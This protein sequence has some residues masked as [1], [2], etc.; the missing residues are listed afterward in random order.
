M[1][2]ELRAKGVEALLQYSVVCI[3]EVHERSIE[4]ELMLTTVKDMLS[5]AMAKGGGG[6][7]PRVVLMSATADFERYRAY[8]AEA[9]PRGERVERYDIPDLGG[10]LRRIL[11]ETEV[12][13]RYLQ[14]VATM[15]GLGGMAIAV[16][17]AQA[18]LGESMYELV[19]NLTAHIV[20]GGGRG[21][22]MVFLPTY[23]DMEAVS[24]LIGAARLRVEVVA[25]HSSVVRRCRL[26][27]SNP[28]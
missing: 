17:T 14:D 27:L 19:V 11:P 5:S 8:F 10:A 12:K 6:G 20:T 26:T 1:V 4:N 7:F 21:H 25:L 9:L 16:N 2:E 15:L 13:V 28:R 23:F 22:V 18:R 3:D 24:R